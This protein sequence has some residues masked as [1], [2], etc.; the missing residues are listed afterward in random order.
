MKAEWDG[1]IRH[2]NICEKLLLVDD[3]HL[4]Y[5]RDLV[6]EKNFAL[7]MLLIGSPED[8]HWTG[9]RIRKE[10]R[11]ETFKSLASPVRESLASN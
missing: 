9:R 8:S 10:L 11:H 5:A 4:H 6:A 3:D 2:I 1:Y 7:S